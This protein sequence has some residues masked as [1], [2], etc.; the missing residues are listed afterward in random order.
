MPA[1]G[2]SRTRLE[3]STSAIRN[4]SVS[5]GRVS[6]M[7]QAQPLQG[8]Q[9]VDLVDRLGGGRNSRGVPTRGK[10]PRV[11][12]FIFDPP[13]DAVDQAGKAEYEAGVDRRAGRATDRF[14]RL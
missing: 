14:P 6:F 2:A 11:G 9:V 10:Q 13:D 7:D 1:S 8:K 3:I 5:C 12:E 4:G